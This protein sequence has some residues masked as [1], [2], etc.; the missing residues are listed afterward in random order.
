MLPQGEVTMKTGKTLM[1]LAAEIQRQAEQKRDFVVP[2][3]KTLMAV[4]GTMLYRSSLAI[5]RSRSA[6]LPTSR[7]ASMPASPSRITTA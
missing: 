1:E 5:R 2:T 7:S 4:R 6:R 3:E